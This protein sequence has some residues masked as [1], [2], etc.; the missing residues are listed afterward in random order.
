MLSGFTGGGASEG[1]EGDEGECYMSPFPGLTC[2]EE[3]LIKSRSQNLQTI[4]KGFDS[5]AGLEAEVCFT[6]GIVVTPPPLPP[7]H[8]GDS[9]FHESP[10]N[11]RG[12]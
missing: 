10:L 2:P 1:L 6:W 3:E 7:L 8:P 5:S 12:M 11:E 9:L 4:I